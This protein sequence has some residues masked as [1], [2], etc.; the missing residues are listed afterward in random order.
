MGDDPRSRDFNTSA[1]SL[2]M[3]LACLHLWPRKHQSIGGSPLGTARQR[4]V[5]QWRRL[6][7]AE[8][9]GG[10]QRGTRSQTYAACSRA[11][12]EIR[13]FALICSSASNPFSTA[14]TSYP[15]SASNIATA[16]PIL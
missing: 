7:P 4:H 2:R 6:I 1:T 9:D 13:N 3:C 11:N 5:G 8:S 14:D 12:D 15:S 16:A 10:L